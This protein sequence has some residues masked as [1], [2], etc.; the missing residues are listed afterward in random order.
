MNKDIN[1]YLSLPYN[2]YLQSI[3][4]EDG[5]GWLA[6]IEEL[7]G[8]IADGETPNE[9]ISNLESA[10]RDWIEFCLEEGLDI[11]E[12]KEDINYSGKF[13]LR[14]SKSI[15]KQL[16]ETADKEGISL[17]ALVNNYIIMGLKNTTIKN[18]I[19]ELFKEQLQENLEVSIYYN[20]KTPKKIIPR[21]REYSLW[22]NRGRSDN[23]F[24][25][26]SRL[27]DDRFRGGI[28]LDK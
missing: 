24:N 23:L 1:Y 26:E 5:G 12:P 27:S 3:S 21:K 19:T 18:I 14:V 11:P 22:T 25:F 13:T 8:C 9:A 16:V 7:E 28:I 20:K 4:E 10:K 6:R 17:N 2:I 15:H